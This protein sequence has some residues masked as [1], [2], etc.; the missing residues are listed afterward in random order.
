MDK[1]IHTFMNRYFDWYIDKDIYIR[2]SYSICTCLYTNIIG[3]VQ[4]VMEMC[5]GGDFRDYVCNQPGLC[6]T[7]THMRPWA[8]KMLRALAYI[9][10]NKI[11]HRDIKPEN[12]I[13]SDKSPGAEVKLIDFGV[14]RQVS[15]HMTR[16]TG[17]ADYVAPEVIQH[18]G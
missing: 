7:E 11:V 4:I 8:A 5:T 14:S 9:H 10:T 16:L 2:L 17:T 3:Y 13:L 15:K 6:I 1:Y 18:G 12:F